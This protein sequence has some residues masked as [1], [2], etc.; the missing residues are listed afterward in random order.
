VEEREAGFR[1]AAVALGLDEPPIATEVLTEAGG[2]RATQTLLHAHP[3]LT[4][5]YAG[6]FAQSVGALRALSDLGLHVPADVSVLSNDNLPL[7]D[8]LQPSLSAMAMPLDELGR[9]AVDTLVDHLEGKPLGDVVLKHDPIAIQRDSTAPLNAE[10][11]AS[12]DLD[13]IRYHPRTSREDSG[14]A[15]AED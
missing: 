15:R 1:Q 11:L 6:T 13:A 12:R 10:R 5:I 2:Y 14:E 4:A 8:Y 7:A 9:L 3:G